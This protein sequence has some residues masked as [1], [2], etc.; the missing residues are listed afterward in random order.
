MAIDPISLTLMAAST[1][2]SAAN[3]KK[4]GNLAMDSAR[5]NAELLAVQNKQDGDATLEGMA[6]RRIENNRALSSIRTRLG[7]SGIRS[8]VGSRGDYLEEAS[9]RMELSILDEARSQEFRAKARDNQAEA[10]IYQGK[11]AKANASG[12]AIASLISGGAKIAN[13]A[14]EVNQNSKPGGNT[15]GGGP[16]GQKWF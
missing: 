12:N 4:Q 14:Y 6:R 5:R 15:F 16:I 7:A 8:D 11:V 10:E 2:M 13:H 1:A 3:A 9:S